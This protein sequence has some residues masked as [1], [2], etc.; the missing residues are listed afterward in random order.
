MV[1]LSVTLCIIAVA[2][3]CCNVLHQRIRRRAHRRHFGLSP[4]SI[5]MGAK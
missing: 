4:R 1:S 3:L 2:F 5:P